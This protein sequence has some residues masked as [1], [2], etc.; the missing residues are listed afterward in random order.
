[1]W[2]MEDSGC[3]G[4]CCVGVV[5][6]GLD[7]VLIQVVMNTRSNVHFAME[8]SRLAFRDGKIGSGDQCGDG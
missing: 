5:R 2:E 3:G 4:F 8:M 1:M 7:M 6:D